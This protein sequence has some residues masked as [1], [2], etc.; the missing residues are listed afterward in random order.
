[1]IS[2]VNNKALV[3]ELLLLRVELQHAVNHDRREETRRV[4]TC[5]RLPSGG[6]MNMLSAAEAATSRRFTRVRR[7]TAP[8]SA[9]IRIEQIQET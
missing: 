8:K 4:R 2:R 3:D 5:F 6:P 9:I 7:N 1:M